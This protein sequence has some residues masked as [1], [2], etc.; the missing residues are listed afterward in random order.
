MPFFQPRNHLLCALNII[1]II[2]CTQTK[3]QNCPD[4]SK[5]SDRL[6]FNC[7]EPRQF[8]ARIKENEISQIKTKQDD[9]LHKSSIDWRE[10]RITGNAI[11]YHGWHCLSPVFPLVGHP[12][13]VSSCG[14]PKHSPYPQETM[15]MGVL[16]Y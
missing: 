6:P 9:S 8:D 4:C 15:R 14:A 2:I 11:H 7:L 12:K 13:R 3:R 16:K 5:L 1:N 10:N